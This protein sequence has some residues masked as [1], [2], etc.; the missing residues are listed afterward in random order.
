M[1]STRVGQIMNTDVLTTRREAELAP[2]VEMMMRRG[3]AEVPVV[4]RDRALVGFVTREKLLEPMRG[5]D[6]PEEYLAHEQLSALVTCELDHGFRLDV[7][8]EVTVRD[9]MS[10]RVIAVKPDTTTRDAAALMKRYRLPQLPVVSALGALVGI[11]SALDL[12]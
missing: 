4:D 5:G 11:I 6:S 1:A 8:A 10:A 3:L 12:V 2:I 9:V 7:G